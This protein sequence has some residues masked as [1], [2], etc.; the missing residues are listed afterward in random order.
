MNDREALLRSVL[1]SPGDD[2]PR[3]VLADWLEERGEPDRAEFVRLQCAYAG[4]G[5]TPAERDRA[6]ALLEAHGPS[7]LPAGCPV[8]PV[9]D[10][11]HAPET[12]SP[13]FFRRGF[14]EWLVVPAEVLLG[15]AA[16]L[17]GSHPVTRV[18]LSFRSPRQTDYSAARWLDGRRW[19]LAASDALP[20]ELYDLL[21]VGKAVPD[22]FH[23][24][25][26]DEGDA[27]VDLSRACVAFGRSAAGLPTPR[28]E[29][30]PA[31]LAQGF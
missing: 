25:Y 8:T 27:L 2:A 15:W 22:G 16:V 11:G 30:G 4:R 1:E 23:R 6:E 26:R 20:G 5:P 31:R 7:W 3:L 13:A 14:A 17:F 28:H 18:R 24:L 10:F 21:A 29:P 19:G 9:P 12:L